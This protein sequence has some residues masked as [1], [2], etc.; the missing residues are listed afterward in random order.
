M[1]IK[2]FSS[3]LIAGALSA[4]IFACSNG[5]DSS[6]EN[7]DEVLTSSPSESDDPAEEPESSSSK[8]SDSTDEDSSSSDTSSTDVPSSDSLGWKAGDT[9]TLSGYV[10]RGLVKLATPVTIYELN[11]NLEETG[12]VYSSFVN[13]SL[14]FYFVHDVVLSSPYVYIKMENVAANYVCE[15]GTATRQPIEALLDLREGLDANLNIL[16]TL[17]A[18]RTK[19]F[20]KKGKSFAE[21]R[22]LAYDELR[23]EFM[24]DSLQLRFEQISM[25]E[26][27]VDNYYLL[28]VEAMSIYETD[29][30]PFKEV[31]FQEDTMNLDYFWEVA[32]AR[33][34]GQLCFKLEEHSKAW[35]YKVKLTQTKEYIKQ[36]YEARFDFGSCFAENYAEVKTPRY[37]QGYE[38]K[39]SYYCDSTKWIHLN[40]YNCISLDQL[41]IDTLHGEIGDMVE[42]AYCKGRFY[43][44]VDFDGWKTATELDVG[45]K[46]PCTSKAVGFKSSGRKCYVCDANDWEE[47]TLPKYDCD[48]RLHECEEEDG[49]IFKGFFNQDSSY[50]CDGSKARRIN[51]REKLFN[52]A[53]VSTSEKKSFEVG[54]STFNCEKGKW[55]LTSG[56]S[57]ANALLDERDG[58]VYRTV[59]LGTQRWMAEELN[60]YDTVSSEYL[61][62]NIYRV[63]QESDKYTITLYSAVA[64]A[65]SVCPAG[66]HVPTQDEWQTLFQFADKYRLASDVVASL[67]SQDHNNIPYYS[68]YFD[69]YGFSLNAYGFVNGQGQYTQNLN[70]VYLWAADSVDGQNVMFFTSR[71]AKEPKFITSSIAAH[72]AS[73]RCVEDRKEE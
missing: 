16:T 55:S 51:E 21:A 43:K 28:G 46:Q 30:G 37:Q 45:L 60:Y 34:A 24:M 31:N 26:S 23:T 4:F 17:Q 68:D 13:D 48:V 47:A 11:E 57:A 6:D 18:W 62:G 49:T 7:R 36:V 15:E 12:V 52:S 40:Q 50:V 3:L 8:V 27:I 19:H 41:V 39:S 67:S 25:A 63:S 22:K 32:Y 73:I 42:G 59:G 71:T 9:I 14:G 58:Q 54:L 33:T 66:Y 38:N 72:R 70:E 56:D 53:C 44:Y 10:N 5:A 65:S 2:K 61:V 35:H 64:K 1:A 69:E 20:M 29:F